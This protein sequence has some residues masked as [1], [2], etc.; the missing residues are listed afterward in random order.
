MPDSPTAMTEADA[1]PSMSSSGRVRRPSTKFSPDDYY[2]TPMDRP[3]KQSHPGSTGTPTEPKVVKTETTS[4]K[5]TSTVSERRAS[6]GKIKFKSMKR[7]EDREERKSMSEAGDA[8]P[9]TIPTVVVDPVRPEKRPRAD[10]SLRDSSKP[11]RVKRVSISDKLSYEPF[12]SGPLPP[13]HTEAFDISVA[14]SSSNIVSS[15]CL[16][17]IYI[18]NYNF[19]FVLIRNCRIFLE[20]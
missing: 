18:V 5:P 6:A 19:F 4:H 16:I 13:L 14:S 2:S 15:V 7:K 20:T 10:S 1:A 9:L 17:I 8:S 3:K 12:S 11:K